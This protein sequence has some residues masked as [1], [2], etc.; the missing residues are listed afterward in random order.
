MF[1]QS[2]YCELEENHFDFAGLGNEVAQSAVYDAPENIHSMSQ[3]NDHN[4]YLNA[5]EM[6]QGQFRGLQQCK[7]F[8]G[9]NAKTEYCFYKNILLISVLLLLS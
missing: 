5:M 8:A 4:S 2:N 3:M 6:D 9:I 1:N 7:H